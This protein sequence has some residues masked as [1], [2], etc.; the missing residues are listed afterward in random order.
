MKTIAFMT[1]AFLPATFFAALF[2]LPMFKWDRTPVIQDKF[3]IYWATTLP[4]TVLVFVLWFLVAKRKEIRER[5]ENK[6]ERAI[7]MKRANTFASTDESFSDS[8]DEEVLSRNGEW[9]KKVLRR[10]KKKEKP[11]SAVGFKG[12]QAIEA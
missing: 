8:E 11:E 9:F 6:K 2:A 1:M 5:L 12:R 4:C 3:W 7:V 10:R